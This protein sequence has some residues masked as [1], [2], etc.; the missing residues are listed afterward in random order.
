MISETGERLYQEREKRVTDAIA[1]RKPDRLPIIVRFHFFPGT[2]AGMTAEELMYDPEKTAESYWKVIRDFEPDMIQNPFGRFLGPLLDA[3]D[4][5]Q[6]RWPGRNLPAH[7]PYQFVEQE[8]MKAEEYDALLSDPSDFIVR[9][10]W[11]RIFGALKGLERLPP[12]HSVTSYSVG[13]LTAFG[14]PE[15]AQALDALGC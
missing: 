15:A 13:M 4:C 6:A 12:L 10:L 7:L 2:Y 9:R 14:S 8:Y 3:L 5:R 1:L 11:P